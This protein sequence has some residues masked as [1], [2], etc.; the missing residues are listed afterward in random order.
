[1][2]V[3]KRDKWQPIQTSLQHR[4][5][6]LFGVEFVKTK[7]AGN[8]KKFDNSNIGAACHAC[9][10]L[11]LVLENLA[12][13]FSSLASSLSNSSLIKAD[14]DMPSCLATMVSLS[15][16]VLGNDKEILII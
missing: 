11:Y 12:R 1:M 7:D 3:S 9:T 2:G 10:C 14:R 15:R 16:S 6:K 4:D 5:A 8:L 13:F